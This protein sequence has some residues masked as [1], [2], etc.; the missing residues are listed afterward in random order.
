MEECGDLN[1]VSR[2]LAMAYETFSIANS[3][4]EEANTIL[5]RHGMMYKKVK[6]KSNNLMQSFDA[7]NSVMDSML[8]TKESK[9]QLC[10]DFDLLQELLD[11][12]MNHD[13]VIK[14]G[15]YTSATLFIHE[16]K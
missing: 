11:E 2:L 14:R 7:Y 12:F 4:A 5:E 8:G 6:T 15:P 3:Y 1:R 13:I 10:N 9:Y 16:K